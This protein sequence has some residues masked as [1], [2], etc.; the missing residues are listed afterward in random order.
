MLELS[1]RLLLLFYICSLGAKFRSCKLGFIY[2]NEMDDFST[3]GIPN[4]FGLPPSECNFIK[5]NKRPLSS[6]VP[7]VLLDRNMNVKLVAGGSGGSIITTAV[8]QVK[9]EMTLQLIGFFGT[10]KP[11]KCKIIGS[12]LF[13]YNP[14]NIW[15][16]VHPKPEQFLPIF[17]VQ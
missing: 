6:S 15:A 10:E 17:S 9:R 12:V 3:P 7:V 16:L 11:I 4:E 13:S 8:A 14:V 5:P 1:T 2:N